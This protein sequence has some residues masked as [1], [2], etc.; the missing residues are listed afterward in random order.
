MSVVERSREEV[1][2]VTCPWAARATGSG[3]ASIFRGPM[4][5]QGR[6]LALAQ[7]PWQQKV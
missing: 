7:F 4:V 1:G 5:S 3:R 6:W 2:G